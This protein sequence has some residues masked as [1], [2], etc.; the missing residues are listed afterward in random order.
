[1]INHEL[2]QRQIAILLKGEAKFTT[3]PHKQST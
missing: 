1:M 2:N 3:P